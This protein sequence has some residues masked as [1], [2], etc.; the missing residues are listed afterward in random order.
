M[1][2]PILL[3]I[4]L[5]AATFCLILFI[6]I[7]GIRIVYGCKSLAVDDACIVQAVESSIDKETQGAGKILL[8]LASLRRLSLLGGDFRVYSS[9]LHRLG[10]RFFTEDHA[11]ED[12]GALCPPLV[13]DGCVHGYVMEHVHQKGLESGIRLCDTASNARLRLGCVHALGHS[14]FEFNDQSIEEAN[15]SFCK[16]YSDPEHSACLSGLFHE[17][18]KFGRGKGHENYYE[19]PHEYHPISC[20]AF[21]DWEYTLCYGAQGSF[22]QYFPES[23]PIQQT[24][25]FC[26]SAQIPAAQKSC[27][28]HARQRLDIARG[29][30]FVEFEGLAKNFPKE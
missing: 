25:E 13:K 3:F 26:E 12:V 19:R 9:P 7:D 27:K 4:S 8:Q 11:F 1:K 5:A 24:Y 18:S 14:Y 20:D 23:E 29:Y 10:S 6:H 21:N 28:Y 17:H 22:R 16:Q 2:K 30:S 15:Q